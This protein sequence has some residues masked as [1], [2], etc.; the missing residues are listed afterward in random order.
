[1]FTQPV[2]VFFVLLACL[3]LLYCLNTI[4]SVLQ[5]NS[6]K[7][8][9][10]IIAFAIISIFLYF[11]Y[12]AVSNYTES[13]L[14]SNEQM[15][16]SV[17]K[18]EGFLLENPDDIRVI[19]ALGSHYMKSG[20]LELAYEK[21][22]SGYRIQGESRDFEINLGLIESTLMV[23]PTDFPYDIDQLIEETL[24]MNPENTQILWLS[25]LI[26][27]GRG[28]TELTIERWS[29]LVNNPEVSLEIQN[30]ISTQLEQ[31]KKMEEGISILNDQ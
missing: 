14:A 31:L 17:E 10:L 24:A 16:D 8:A 23:R 3:G 12:E 5:S 9:A 2:F 25:G 11:N 28:D 4:S 7:S 1:M 22:L 6:Q 21:F 13:Q 19:K 26:A 29:G 27:M 20:R 15:I 30:S 18:L